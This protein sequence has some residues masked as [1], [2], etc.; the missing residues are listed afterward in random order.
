MDEKRILAA[1]FL[2]FLVVAVYQWMLPVQPPQPA[3]TSAVSTGAP[4]APAASGSAVA[5]APGSTSPADSAVAQL[6]VAPAP[7]VGATPI[8]ADSAARDIVVDTDSV[9]AVFS[10]GGA[11]L[12][13]WKLKHYLESGQPL[14][15]VPVD[16]PPNYARPFT[17]STDDAELSKTL[18]T[19]FFKPSADSLTLGASAGTLTFTYRDQSGLNARKTFYFQPEG[20]AYVLKVEAS[21]D[22]AGASRPVTLAWGPGVG[23]GHSPDGSTTAQVRGIQF[24]GGKV[25]Y[26][27]ASSL[28]SSAHFE[29]DIRFAGAEDHYFLRVVLPGSQ[30][31]AV[32]YA[33]VSLPLPD[34]AGKTRDFVSYSVSVPGSFGMQYFMGPKDFD[35]L[36]SVDPQL[37]RAIEFGMFD[38]IVVPLLLALKWINGF[39]GNYGWSIVVLTI[40]INLVMFPLR[41]RS[42]VS[43]KKMQAVQ[44]EMKAIQDRYAKYKMTDPERQKMNQEMMAL[45][46]AK[47]VN[48]A[49]G[50]LPMLLTLPILFAFYA[51]LAAAIEL[52]GAPFLGWI[53]DLSRHD[54]FYVTPI[55]MG[56]TQFIQMRMTPTTADPVQQKVFMLMPLIFT[57]SFL[58]AP[59]GL[60]LY[61][62][63]SNL[64]AIGQQ[65]LT[66]RIIGT[67]T[68]PP[69]AKTAGNAA[70][71]KS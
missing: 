17:M 69:R 35:I 8:E 61:W 14:E 16:L 2:S 52:R 62:F 67:P 19:A 6:P 40:L 51:M 27:T 53:H 49:G 11:T 13:S 54:P 60:A 56:A 22:R 58:W 45:Y 70:G 3:P 29:G 43:M 10:T 36:R 65:F 44:P 41:H 12:R 23:L 15:L 57:F 46:K 21:V 50:C 66:N 24:I 5:P 63:V 31:V 39:V 9:R 38:V 4:A 18:A 55:L 47:G 71:A 1:I 32:D 25:A 20:K 48:P 33:P 64:L 7:S 42:M 26:L 37:V 59:A 28:A 30:K 68:P 34:V